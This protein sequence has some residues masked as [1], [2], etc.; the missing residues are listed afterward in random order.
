[1][2]NNSIQ[3]FYANGERNDGLPEH[4]MWLLK[5]FQRYL[6]SIGKQ[7]E[8]SNEIYPQIKKNLLAIVLASLEDTDLEE[9]TFELNGADLMIGNDFQPILL[10]INGN[11][12]LSYTTKTTRDIC[13]RVMEDVVKGKMSRTNM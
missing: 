8:W 9:N 10:E 13:P 2:T 5:E 12:D 1:M 3:R 11:P 6:R 7:N 4:N